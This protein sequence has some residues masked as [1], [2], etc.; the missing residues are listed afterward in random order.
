MKII[1]TLFFIIS[2]LQ[3]GE[4][5]SLKGTCS[6]GKS[7]LVRSL[8]NEGLVI[9]DEDSIMHRGYVDAVAMRFPKAFSVLQ[10]AIADE[11]LYHALRENDVL[12]KKENPEASIALKLIQDELNQDL[13]WKQAVSQKIDQ[14]ILRRVKDALAQSKNVLVDSWYIKPD[15]LALEFPETKVTRILLYCPLATAYKRFLKRNADAH[16]KGDLSEKR[17][18]RQLIGSYV[19][20]YEISSKPLQGIEKISRADLDPIFEEMAKSLSGVAPYRKTVFTFDTLSKGQFLEMQEGFLRPF[21]DSKEAL[22]LSPK[23]HY[24]RVVCNG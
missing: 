18:L 21:K 4:I 3:A 16:L 24:D 15:R 22:Y 13:P 23:E 7:T 6:A 20:L 17:Y 8:E 10:G 2:S 5:I 14:E 11:N 12:F 19:S 1:F 9:I